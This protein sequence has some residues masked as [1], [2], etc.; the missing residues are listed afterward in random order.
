M[1]SAEFHLVYTKQRDFSHAFGMPL[2]LWP[3]R[4]GF[5]PPRSHLDQRERSHFYKLSI[6]G[7]HQNLKNIRL[8][9]SYLVKC[10]LSV[11]DI[12][13]FHLSPDACIL[14][15]HFEQILDRRFCNK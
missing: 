13:L 10:P 1:I 5:A 4:G 12:A 9:E 3:Q 7:N 8:L 11:A 15:S 6:E 2:V 14:V